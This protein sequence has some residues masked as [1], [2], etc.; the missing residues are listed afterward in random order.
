MNIANPAL[1]FAAVTITLLGVLV[2]RM[3]RPYDTSDSG[4]L[5]PIAVGVWLGLTTTSWIYAIY[6]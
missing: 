4:L 3:V 1:T 5:T 2:P 6:S